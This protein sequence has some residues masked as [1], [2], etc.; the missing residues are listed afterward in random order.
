L[1]LATRSARA[2]AGYVELDQ[3]GMV[4][5]E[6][7][8]CLRRLARGRVGRVAVTF[9]ALPAVFPVN[10][11]MFEGDVLF[12]TTSG[13]KLSAAVRNDIIAFEIDHV[14]HMGHL[15]WS[16]LVIGPSHEVVEPA[17]FEAA[18]RAPLARWVPGGPRIAGPS[19][20][21]PG[22]R[23]RADAYRPSGGLHMKTVAPASAVCKPVRLGTS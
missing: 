12:R 7:D 6:R 5:L 23:P 13:S 15:G 14:D 17:E 19:S 21:G 9:G 11:T 10:F 20:R 4:V 22:H 8:E 18:A 2:E 3:N 16:V 1:A